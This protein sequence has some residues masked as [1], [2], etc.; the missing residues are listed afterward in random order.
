MPL[1]IMVLAAVIV[2]SGASWYMMRDTIEPKETRSSSLRS[3]WPNNKVKTLSPVGA[4]APLDAGWQIPSQPDGGVLPV[5]EPEEP[6]DPIDDEDGVTDDQE[7][8]DSKDDVA[9]PKSIEVPDVD[10]NAQRKSRELTAVGLKLYSQGKYKKAVTQ[11][12]KALAVSP[13][14]K[15]ALVAYTKSLLEVERFRDALEAAEKAAR[16]DAKNPE[17]FLLL[18]NARQDLGQAKGSI[19]AYEQYLKLD[20]SGQFATEVRQVIRGMQAGLN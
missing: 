10:E 15:P 2:V 16:I 6:A 5:A 11:F 8:A 18:G 12:E 19:E 14:S 7:V 1:I 3:K 20:P 13:G 4:V 17:V 9:K